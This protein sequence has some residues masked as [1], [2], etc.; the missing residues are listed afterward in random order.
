MNV[1]HMPP[2]VVCIYRVTE[3][4]GG[5]QSVRSVN[6][7]GLLNSV[8]ECGDDIERVSTGTK[9]ALRHWLNVKSTADT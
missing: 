5:V 4:C 7:G 2:C 9:F 6:S 1:T 3:V 8:P